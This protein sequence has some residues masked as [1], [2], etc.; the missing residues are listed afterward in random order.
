MIE[1][2]VEVPRAPAVAG[3]TSRT[4]A[5][6]S[7]AERGWV[8]VLVGLVAT[9]GVACEAGTAPLSPAVE[10]ATCDGSYVDLDDEGRIRWVPRP[11]TV[12]TVCGTGL[13]FQICLPDGG[14]SETARSHGLPAP[15]GVADAKANNPDYPFCTRPEDCG[16]GD[17]CLFEPGCDAP[18]G[19]CC[20]VQCNANGVAPIADCRSISGCTLEL[21]G[22]EGEAVHGLPLVPFASVG[23][24]AP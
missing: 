15:E 9:I 18:I 7:A 12:G 2:R 16:L 5:A 8:A 13:G 20:G 17:V 21:C 14:P 1:R 19:V 4:S 23:P 10:P 24:C 22:C 6:R 11:C 3:R